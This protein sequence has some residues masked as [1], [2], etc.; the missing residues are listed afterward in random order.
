MSFP[1]AGTSCRIGR[2]FG[3]AFSFGAP[4]TRVACYVDGFNLYHAVSDLGRQHL[5]WLDIQRLAQSICRP[6]E[7]LV[8]TAYFSAYATWLPAQYARH[9]QYVSALKATGVDCHMARFNEKQAGCRSCGATWKTHEEK[10]TDV[11]F[12]LT[13][14]EDAIDNVFDR[15]ILISA[16]GDHV[17]A[18][19][20]VRARLPAKQIFL[21]APPGRLGKARELSKVCN[22][23]L[24]ITA[25]RL[26]KCLLPAEFLS[27]DGTVIAS[28]PSAYSP[29]P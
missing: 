29:R 18:V 19:R 9:R 26:E 22:S 13:F 6:G 21:A 8:K 4:M 28:R 12:S 27:A 7:I 14:L 5:K 3:P 11:H 1:P 20:R 23:G 25:G 2:S 10:E 24:E 16:D 17:P 15:A